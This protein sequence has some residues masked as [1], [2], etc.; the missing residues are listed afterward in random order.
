[1]ITR[2][3]YI[4]EA[5][6]FIRIPYI[7][8]GENPEIGLDC[9]GL[10]QILLAILNLDPKGDQTADGLYRHFL[11]NG[12]VVT[13]DLYDLGDIAFFGSAKKVTH[14]TGVLDKEL[15]IEAGGGGSKT[16]TVEIA[17][18][19]KAM[20]RVRKISARRDLVAVIR[21]NGL[22]WGQAKGN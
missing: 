16:T 10:M 7:W 2:E 14:I 17:N 18:Q 3:R 11:N 4:I 15:M 21:P 8:G 6:K 9:S 22:P 13:P 5:M 1:M 19:M 12:T 20:V